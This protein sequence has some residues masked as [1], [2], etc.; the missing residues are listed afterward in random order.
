MRS[1]PTMLDLRV[2]VSTS[3]DMLQDGGVEIRERDVLVAYTNRPPHYNQSRITVNTPVCL[4]IW[5]EMPRCSAVLWWLNNHKSHRSVLF[6][7]GSLFLSACLLCHNHDLHICPGEH[8]HVCYD[9]FPEQNAIT[10]VAE[11]PQVWDPDLKLTSSVRRPWAWIPTIIVVKFSF[12]LSSDGIG[13]VFVKNNV[14]TVT[15]GD[16][17]K[18]VEGRKMNCVTEY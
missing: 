17:S 13:I 3:L 16:K 12:S 5:Q 10:K 8:N 18:K 15:K 6:V 4:F 14:K 2:N 11:S 7:T 9:V 1:F